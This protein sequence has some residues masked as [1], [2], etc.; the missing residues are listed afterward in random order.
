MQMKSSL[1]S[2]E[3]AAAIGGFNSI[4]NYVFDFILKLIFRTS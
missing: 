4:E 2:D 1:R 3:V